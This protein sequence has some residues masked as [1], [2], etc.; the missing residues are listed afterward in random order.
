MGLE[1]FPRQFHPAPIDVST[2]IVHVSHPDG[3]RRGIRDNSETLFALA[4]CAVGLPAIGIVAKSDNDAHDFPVCP[5]RRR[6]VNDRKEA[7][8]L[9][10]EHI[11]MFLEVD[12]LLQNSQTRTLIGWKR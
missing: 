11:L 3:N 1:G 4:H 12:V 5:Q 2:G 9:P 7:A 6:T 10:N 8:I